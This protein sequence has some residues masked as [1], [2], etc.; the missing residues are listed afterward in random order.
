MLIAASVVISI[1]LAPV[2][3]LTTEMIVGSAPPERAGAASGI[4]ETAAELGGAL[5]IAILGS[6]GVAVYRG[7]VASDLP[8][9]VPP[10]AAEAARD[11]LGG[12]VAVAGELPAGLGATV[13]DVAR[14]AFVSGMHLTAGIATIIAVGLAVLAVVALRSHRLGGDEGGDESVDA[15]APGPDREPARRMPPEQVA[16]MAPC[17]FEGAD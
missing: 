3:G 17:L 8:A 7:E 15:S 10:V 6:V 2:F 9:S 13:L 1:G 12:A 11:T 4:S 14:E 16:D 5:G